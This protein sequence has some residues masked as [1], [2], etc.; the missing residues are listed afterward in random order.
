[1]SLGAIIPVLRMFDEAATRAF[2]LNYLG[3]EWAWEH[4]FAPDLPLYA[5]IVR[6]GCQIHLTQHHG[7][8]TPG[9]A[10]RIACPALDDL[11]AEL[12]GKGYMFARPALETQPW[13]MR[14]VTVTDPAGNRLTFFADL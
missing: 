12:S 10:I 7:D 8:A 6:D 3:F 9:S 13:D 4:R 2:Y 11:Y 1:M 14:E 5:G